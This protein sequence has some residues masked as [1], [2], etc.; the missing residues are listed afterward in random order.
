MN[1]R[2]YMHECVQL[3]DYIV[4][5][6]EKASGVSVRNVFLND[7]LESFVAQL[8]DPAVERVRLSGSPDASKLAQPSAALSEA[9][10]SV[11]SC[12]SLQSIVSRTEALDIDFSRLSKYA[13]ELVGLCFFLRLAGVT[14]TMVKKNDLKARDYQD[15]LQ[16]DSDALSDLLKKCELGLGL[17]A[18]LVSQGLQL[19][20]RDFDV[21]SVNITNFNRIQEF[22]GNDQ[23]HIAARLAIAQ[24]CARLYQLD[25]QFDAAP[26]IQDVSQNKEIAAQATEFT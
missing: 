7:E 26:T 17:P 22:V 13:R 10:M 4:R 8:N 14:D 21:L 16:I 15:T 1:D 9:L 11:T 3:V 12:T 2:N 24:F 19:F 23:V 5:T 25:F 18:S 6:V 20:A